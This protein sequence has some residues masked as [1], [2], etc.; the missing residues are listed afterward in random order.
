MYGRAGFDWYDHLVGTVTAMGWI[1]IEGWALFAKDR[2]VLFVYIDDFVMSGP[3]QQV[4]KFFRE[5]MGKID[6]EPPEPIEEILSIDVMF[7]REPPVSSILLPQPHYAKTLVQ[8]YLETSQFQ[9]QLRQAATPY[10]ELPVHD[11]RHELPGTNASCCRIHIGGCLFL[12]RGARPDIAFA[13]GC[14]ARKVDRWTVADD[15]ALH[16]L[17]EYIHSTT[18][19]K[20]EMKLIAEGLKG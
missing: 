6:L 10:A 4:T 19:A 16:R 14:V 9:K 20:L 18:E 3:S 1:R 8:R 15:I 7:L 13:V 11:N 5:L 17:M 12:A 2:C